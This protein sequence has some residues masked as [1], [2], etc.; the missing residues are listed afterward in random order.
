[1]TEGGSIA[2]DVL[3][4]I[5]INFY[6]FKEKGF[7]EYKTDLHQAIDEFV[8]VI[9]WYKNMCTEAVAIM[10]KENQQKILHKLFTES[11]W[12]Y[13][14]PWLPLDTLWEDHKKIDPKNYY[15]PL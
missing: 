6:T 4:F 14:L 2:F 8:R 11:S 3:S 5:D 9:A 7:R 12:S 10:D 15:Q 13:Y 1:M